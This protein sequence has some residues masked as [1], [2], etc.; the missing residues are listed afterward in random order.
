MPQ[1]TSE[2]RLENT[3]ENTQSFSRYY[4]N[5]IFYKLKWIENV[6]ANICKI[7]NLIYLSKTKFKFTTACWVLIGCLN[8]V[9]FKKNWFNAQQLIDFLA[10]IDIR[11]YRL[12]H[13]KMPFTTRIIKRSRNNATSKLITHIE[14]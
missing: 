10:A 13:F 11:G 4:E 8:L 12:K 3:I 1:F 7:N 6:I 9:F 5:T 14:N 2:R